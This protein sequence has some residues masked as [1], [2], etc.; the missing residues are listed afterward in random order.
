MDYDIGEGECLGDEGVRAIESPTVGDLVITEFLANPESTDSG[1]EWFELYVAVGGD[2]GDDRVSV[3]LNGLEIG[4]LA[5]DGETRSGWDRF[6]TLESIDCL[7]VAA[8]DWLLF[9]Q[10]DDSVSNGDLPTPDL[11]ASSA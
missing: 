4:R 5:W 2:T 3:D 7:S 11:S 8:G 9:A 10:S 1:K 6:D